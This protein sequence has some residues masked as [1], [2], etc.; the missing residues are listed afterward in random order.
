LHLGTIFRRPLPQF[1]IPARVTHFPVAVPLPLGAVIDD[2]FGGLDGLLELAGIDFVVEGLIEPRD[3]LHLL[4]RQF[5]SFLRRRGRPHDQRQRQEHT[6]RL[7]RSPPLGST[8][9]AIASTA[10][11]P[12]PRRAR[13]SS[14]SGGAPATFLMLPRSAASPSVSG[15]APCGS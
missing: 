6:Q 10:S 15:Y 14:A 8:G 5:T 9:N 2:L 12:P 13:H 1:H 11:T 4:R 3:F 7:H